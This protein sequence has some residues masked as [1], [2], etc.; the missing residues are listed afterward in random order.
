MDPRTSVFLN[1]DP[2]VDKYPHL[3]PYMY[4]AGNPIA[5]IDPDGEKLVFADDAKFTYK[6]SIVA[7]LTKG[8]LL[9]KSMRKD[10][11]TLI[12]SPNTHTIAQYNK[13]G[14]S[15]KSKK[16]EAHI[17][18]KPNAPRIEMDNISMKT[19][20]NPDDVLANAKW[21]AEEKEIERGLATGKGDG[22]N[23]YL[24]PKKIMKNRLRHLGI[25]FT[26]Y[27]S[28]ELDHAVNIDI[29]NRNVESYTV[30]DPNYKY[31]SP[32]E[33]SGV[34]KQNDVAKELNRFKLFNKNKIRDS[35]NIE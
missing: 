26:V 2:L 27:A 32:F 16:Y 8:W 22:S 19:Y 31:D 7:T 5:Y 33:K 21:V 3:S 6:I 14:G 1:I 11:N 28:H 13:E 23:I 18:S 4:C 10:I 12:S 34:D 30:D 29:G 15:A 24:A 20:D 9:S 35:Y 17:K 25:E